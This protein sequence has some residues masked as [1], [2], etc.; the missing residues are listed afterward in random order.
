VAGDEV[1]GVGGQ[2]RQLA[3]ARL[4]LV[5]GLDEGGDVGKRD[6]GAVG[7]VVVVGE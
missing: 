5:A 6:D 3:L 1:A 7:L 2:Q 4:E